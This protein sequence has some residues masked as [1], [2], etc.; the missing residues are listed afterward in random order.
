M[1]TKKV[2][3]KLKDELGSVI[4]TV[5]TKAEFAAKISKLKLE[6]A[7]KNLKV[8]SIMK[9]IGAYVYNRKSEFKQDSYI[10]NVVTE[11]EEMKQEI[12]DLKT[13]MAD[14]RMLHKDKHQTP[15]QSTK[16]K[17]A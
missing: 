5:A 4:S 17:E 7:Q 14:L 3:K 12:E 16:H 1:E 8:S 11:I 6:I 13:K 10:S 15:G 9:D 2:L